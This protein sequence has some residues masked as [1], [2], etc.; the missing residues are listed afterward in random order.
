MKNLIRKKK[1][2]IKSLK[3]GEISN[4]KK[5]KFRKFQIIIDKRI[6]FK[7]MNNSTYICLETIYGQIVSFY[8]NRI[9]YVIAII[10]NFLST[11]VFIRIIRNERYNGQMYKYFLLKSINEFFCFLILIFDIPYYCSECNLDDDYIMQVWFVYFYW[12]GT[13]VLFTNS[14]YLD[15]LATLDCYISIINKWNF[16]L[17]NTFFYTSC[18]IIMVFDTF[19]SIISLK[20]YE[21]YE[22]TDTIT[23]E[24]HYKN[25]HTDYFYSKRGRI[26]D[27]LFALY[28][29]LL[30]FCLLIIL[31][32]LILCIIKKTYN[33]KLK[34][35]Y[36]NTA[37][38]QL[39]TVNIQRAKLKKM[40][41]IIITGSNFIVFNIFIIIFYLP[42]PHIGNFWQCFE[43]FAWFLFELSFINQSI[44]F[45]LFNKV[46]KKYLLLTL[47]FK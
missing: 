46:F 27:I 24:T 23:N 25:K 42:F 22:F 6:T 26:F 39:D 28:R 29:W 1:K 4:F 14:R 9:V 31:N 20:Q 32:I 37:K 36:G 5:N 19:F 38:R 3:I 16:V 8:L 41:M 35:S 30:P 2:L 34:L 15:V 10:L 43:I 21:I 18:F 47:K 11:I 45:F 40:R 33:N 12:F 7:N 17:K 44:I 13:L